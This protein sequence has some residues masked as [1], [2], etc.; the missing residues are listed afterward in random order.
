VTIREVRWPRLERGTYS[1]EKDHRT[2][3]K[4]ADSGFIVK[5]PEP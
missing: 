2:V 1:R 3:A 4:V 5:S